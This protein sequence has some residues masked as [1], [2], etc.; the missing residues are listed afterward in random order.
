MHTG[1]RFTDK[2]SA[3]PPRHDPVDRLNEHHTEDLAIIAR[4]YGHPDTISARAD[5][6]EPGGIVITADTPRGPETTRIAF[7]QPASKLRP[8]GLRIAF[9]DLAREA[10]ASLVCDR[11]ESSVP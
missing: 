1:H 5:R 3:T 11:S 10:G 9:R 8:G 4:A 6:V 2:N 7:P